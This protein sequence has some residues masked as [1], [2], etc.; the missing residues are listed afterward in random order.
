MVLGTGD[1]MNSDVETCLANLL[2]R[3]EER[4]KECYKCRLVI[5]DILITDTVK[6][7][8][9]DLP[10]N[11]TAKNGKTQWRVTQLKSEKRFVKTAAFS[12]HYREEQIER[13]F[14]NKVTNFPSALTEGSSMYHSSKSDLLLSDS[15]RFLKL[16]LSHTTRRKN[17]NGRILISSCQCAI[18]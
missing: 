7:C 2:K 12:I 1:V 11:V 9:L 18:K 13:V 10:D 6:T 8:E 14:S 17:C 15:S 16:Y 3:N 4:Y 5:C